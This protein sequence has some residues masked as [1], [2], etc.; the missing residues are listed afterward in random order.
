MYRHESTVAV[1][2]AETDAMGVVHH[3]SYIVWF[4]VGRTEWLEALGTTYA[5]FERS[6]FF[7]VVAEVGAHYRRP[8]RYGDPIRLLT[9]PSAIKSRAIRFHYEVRHATTDELMVSG[10][11]QHILTDHDG[12]IRTWPEEMSGII[13]Q[14]RGSV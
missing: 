13:E 4:E 14:S 1:R 10:F 2:Y 6:G 7:L 9:W 11:T 12:R 5:D 3:A 8:V